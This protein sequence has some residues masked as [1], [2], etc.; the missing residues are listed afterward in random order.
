M[1]RKYS[2]YPAFDGKGAQPGTVKLV[3]LCAEKWK[4]KSLGIYTVRLMRNSNTQGK[5]IGDPGMEKWLSVHST[6]AACDIGYPDRKT[7]IAIWDFLLAHTKELGIEEI[8]DYAFDKN[9]ADGKP[10]YGRGFRCSRG[11]NAAGVKI[12]TKDDNAGSFGGRWLHVELSPAMAK[13]ADKFTKAWEACS[14]PE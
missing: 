10:G 6:G 7:G 11:E 12:F 1:P 4:T 8:H 2:Y 9:H 3:A 5:N 14:K 13:D